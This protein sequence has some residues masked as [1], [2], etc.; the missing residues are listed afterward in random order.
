MGQS[1]GWCE[2]TDIH[3]LRQSLRLLKLLIMEEELCP[4]W[5][6]SPLGGVF[7]LQEQQQERVGAFWGGCSMDGAFC[8]AP[9][10]LLPS[11]PP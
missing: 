4:Y 10:T 6:L 3:F 7:Q 8:C 11:F 1:L 9:S 5:E 2:L